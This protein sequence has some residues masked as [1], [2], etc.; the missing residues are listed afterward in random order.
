MNLIYDFETLSL[1]RVN[2]VVVNLA[3]LEF[4]ETRFKDNPYTF[5]ELVSLTRF[6]KF[7][8]LKQKNRGRTVDQS[9]LSWWKTLPSDI[10]N[11]IIPTPDDKDTSTLPDFFA[12]FNWPEINR[13]FTRGN[14]FDPIILEYLLKETNTPLPY[15]Y[16]KLRDTR[17]FLD[18]FLYNTPYNDRFMPDNLDIPFQKHNPL[19]D[20]SIDVMR[21]QTILKALP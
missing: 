15:D 21:L 11:Q 2:G 8:T 12:Q 1:D 9:V 14:T 7:D 19:H 17:S 18:A 3:V 16:W 13:V 6:I 5:S 10:S 4:D 20:V